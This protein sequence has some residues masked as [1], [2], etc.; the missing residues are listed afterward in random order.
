MAGLLKLYVRELPEPLLPFNLYKRFTSIDVGS[1]ESSKIIEELK[2]LVQ[3]IPK[4]H[5]KVL[6]FLLQLLKDVS[7]YSEENLMTV[8]NLAVVFGPNILRPREDSP[9]SISYGDST[10]VCSVTEFLIE[11]QELIFPIVPVARVK[12][13]HVRSGGFVPGKFSQKRGPNST[14]SLL[15]NNRRSQQLPKLDPNANQD[16]TRKVFSSFQRTTVPNS[17]DIK[18]QVTPEL[19][20]EYLHGLLLQEKDARTKLEQRLDKLEEK[21]EKL[22]N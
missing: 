19:S 18:P 1:K 9:E 16:V 15:N 14:T 22:S 4:N 5:R 7:K 17:V 6:V 10:T 3:E 2:G 11:K 21:L 8:Q 12:S 13:E 20:L